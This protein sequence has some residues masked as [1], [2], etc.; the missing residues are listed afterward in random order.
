MIEGVNGLS[1]MPQL[2]LAFTEPIIGL[3]GQWGSR[4][5]FDKQSKTSGCR[6]VVVVRDFRHDPAEEV[7][8]RVVR[9]S[10]QGIHDVFKV[11][12]RFVTR[13]GDFAGVLFLRLGD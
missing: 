1:V 4:V 5:Q 9:R 2:I 6:F 12:P 7:T 10:R 13:R 8:I 3:Y 11:Q